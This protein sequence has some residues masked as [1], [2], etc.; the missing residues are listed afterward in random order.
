MRPVGKEVRRVSELLVVVVLLF[1][2]F[3][4]GSCGTDRTEIIRDQ[5]YKVSN[6]S[7]QMR[8]A[9]D[10]ALAK[11]DTITRIVIQRDHKAA[12]QR[13]SLIQVLVYTDSVFA[14]SNATMMELRT[15]Y[16][17]MRARVTLVV[18]S[19][20]SLQASTRDLIA[21]NALERVATNTA[22]AAS[23][24]AVKAWQAVANAERKEGRKKF[25]RGVLIGGVV[26]G[27]VLVGGSVVYLAVA[28]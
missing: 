25:W 18:T 22:L 10:S 11:R 9:R 7:R 21:A 16:A 5:A 12:A 17:V 13:D 3:S 24:S 15:G 26:V 20:D 23:D 27:V 19:Y 4:A 14:D 28:L 2:A 8:Y 1:V 6:Y